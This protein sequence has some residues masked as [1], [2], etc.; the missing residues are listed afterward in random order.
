MR[1]YRP[2]EPALWPLLGRCILAKFTVGV[3]LEPLLRPL[4]RRR[5]L[6]SSVALMSASTLRLVLLK[7]AAYLL[8]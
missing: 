2:L 6:R 5:V 8:H 3:L 7:H 1:L 4:P